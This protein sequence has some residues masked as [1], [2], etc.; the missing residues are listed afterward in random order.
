MVI[1]Q[2]YRGEISLDISLSLKEPAR[3][4]LSTE[5]GSWCLHCCS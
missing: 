4:H 5:E 3:A 1:I 2:F